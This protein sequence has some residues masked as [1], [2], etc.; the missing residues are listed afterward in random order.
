MSFDLHIG[1]HKTA[2]SFIQLVLR[3]NEDLLLKNKIFVPHHRYTRKEIT[4]PVQLYAYERMGLNWKTKYTKSELHI[5]VDQFF[6]GLTKTGADHFILSD[7]NFLGHCGHL[8]RG[9]FLYTR[10]KPFLS[11]LK[12]ALP[13]EPT[14]IFLAVRNYSD[15]F[16]AAYAQFLLDVEVENFVQPASFV[17]SIMTKYPNWSNLVSI[18][19]ET[20]PHSQIVVWTYENCR[21]AWPSIFSQMVGPN[22]AKKMDMTVETNIRPTMSQLA[23]LK[24]CNALQERGVDTALQSLRSYIKETHSIGDERMQMFSTEQVRQLQ[25]RYA[26]HLKMIDEFG[27]KVVKLC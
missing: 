26:K 27:P 3:Q 16:T 5:K 11:A 24:F 2:T 1:A 9:G 7:E 22:T 12:S 6:E 4:I 21:D 14:R 8:V 19:N 10:K 13:E 15:F 23:Y 17:D 25:F 20:F 18:L